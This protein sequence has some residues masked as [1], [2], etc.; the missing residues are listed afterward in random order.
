[1]KTGSNIIVIST[2]TNALKKDS[3]VYNRMKKYSESFDSFH[4]FVFGHKNDEK[5]ITEENLTIYNVSV[6][7]IIFKIRKLL[8]SYAPDVEF[9]I[10]SQD[11]FEVGLISYL[12][13]MMYNIP[14]NAQI[15]TDFYNQNFIAESLRGKL[16]FIIAKFLIKKSR[17]LR[18]VSKRIYEKLYYNLDVPNEKLFLAPIQV[19]IEAIDHKDETP[20][21]TYNMLMLSRIE[22]V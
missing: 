20:K 13:S 12:I 21:D 15:H 9:V 3:R 19:D 2:D 22:K 10:S 5:I 7:N 4:V 8:K 11:V 6:F 18:V 14:F 16:Q 17:T 1:M